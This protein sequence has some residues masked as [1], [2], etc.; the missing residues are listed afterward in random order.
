MMHAKQWKAHLS[1]VA[2]RRNEAGTVAKLVAV[3]GGG[4]TS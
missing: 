1:V 3:G 4:T 2:F